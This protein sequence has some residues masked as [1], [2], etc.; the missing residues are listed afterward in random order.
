MR[1]S[2]RVSES[3]AAGRA[4]AGFTLVEL[5]VVIAIIGIMI[6]LLLPAVQ[7]AREAA[8]R[9]QCANNLRQMG[10]ALHNYHDT[11]RTFPSGM[12]WPNRMFWS[13]Q[14][15]PFIEQQALHERINPGA[16]W[17]LPPNAPMLAVYLSVY[18][19]PVSAAPR[20]LNAAGI[21]KRVPCDYNACTSG[22]IARESG[23]APLAGRSDADG[24]FFVNSGLGMPEVLDG[25]SYTVAIGEVLFSYEPHG[26]DH[27]GLQ[28]YLDHWYIGTPEGYGN[29]I[30]ESMSSTA[31]PLN[32]WRDP[33]LFVDE[34][35]LSFGSRHPGGAQ[36][37]FADGHSNFIFE[38]ID[39][40]VW[41]ALGTRAN[42]EV[43]TGF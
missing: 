6:A 20:D 31:C 9:L 34:K 35:E 43:A 16:P 17:H 3:L 32:A 23:P 2:S 33:S 11:R 14:L 18:R 42:S 7:A 19:C 28:Q 4:K 8:R 22:L 12:S 37:L 24:L 38:T 15:L 1:G 25:T 21:V 13:G 41:S 5:L 10:I 30:S 40:Q 36:V 29:E 39:R 27:F 26:A